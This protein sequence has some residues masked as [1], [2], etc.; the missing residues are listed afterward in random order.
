MTATNFPIHAARPANQ[1][2]RISILRGLFLAGLPLVL[3]G[4][5]LWSAAPAAALH[6]MG[7]IL[8]FA[9]ILGRFWATLYIGGHKNGQLMQDGPYSVCRHPL[10]LFSIIGI[11]GFGLVL[12]SITL[13]ALFGLA[14]VLVLTT[15]ALHEERFLQARFGA[16]HEAYRAAVPMIRPRLSDFRTAEQVTIQPRLLWRNGRDALVFLSALPL[17][18]AI[19]LAHRSGHLHLLGLW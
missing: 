14:G 17:A 11:V 13:A 2:L 12:E 3:L 19:D 9:A 16:S 1:R 4:F 6:V 18:E 5:P 7:T 10:Y 15:I 8:I